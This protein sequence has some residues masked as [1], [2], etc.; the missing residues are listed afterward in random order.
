[1][2]LA[3]NKLPSARTR[4]KRYFW[5][6][7]FPNAQGVTFAHSIRDGKRTKHDHDYFEQLLVLGGSGR[8]LHTSGEVALGRGASVFI[9]PLAWH[10]YRE[11][12]NLELV[13]CSVS[14]SV[15]L[16][17]L[18]FVR[19]QPPWS[20]VHGS[21]RAIAFAT[22][23]V[24]KIRKMV[25]GWLKGPGHSSRG[26][27]WISIGA[28][29]QLLGHTRS[30]SPQIGN[31]NRAR[32]FHPLTRRAID[33]MSDRL[34]SPLRLKDLAEHLH[35]THPVYFSKVF[36]D[37]VGF[38]PMAY[39]NRLRCTRAASLLRSTSESI[40]EI[41]AACGWD[42]PNLFSRRFRALF[43]QSPSR[44]RSARVLD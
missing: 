19:N 2:K 18:A 35:G 12:R 11:C 23:F 17:E 24:P 34:A 3:Q 21:L 6:D 10:E 40:G 14:S 37:D 42:D 9:P 25:S 4:S 44:Y 43:S 26:D 27:S 28:Y 38:P 31:Q 33:Y 13:F 15:M 41:G 29:L 16:K 39:F 36:T 1:M 32:S 7:V 22:S 30:R 20:L 8:L 5:P